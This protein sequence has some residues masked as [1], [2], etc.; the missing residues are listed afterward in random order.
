MTPDQFLLLVDPLPEPT[1]LVSSDG[2]IVA[3]NHAVEERLGMD[4]SWLRTQRLAEVVAESADEVAHFLRLC[5][6]SRSLVIGGMSLLKNGGEAVACRFEGAVVQPKIKGAAALLI[7]RIFPIEEKATQFNALN[8]RIDELGWEVQRRQFAEEKT[9]QRE[10]WLKVTLQSIGDGVICTDPQ[11]YVT[12]MNPI[13][14]FL[15][16]WTEEESQAQP[17]STVFPI[18]NEHTKKPVENPVDKVL[19]EGRIVG[20]ANHTVL[21]ARDGTHRPIDDSAAPIRDGSGTLLG[22]VLIFRDVSEQRL[23]EQELRASEARKSAIVD[24]SLDCIIT[25]DHQ[26]NVVEFNPAAERTFGHRREEVIGRQLADII[27]PV[28]LRDRHKRGMAHY[29]TT[30]EG[31]VLGKRLELPALR[32]DGTEFP[33]ELA[34]TR[35]PTNGP[36]LFTA[37]LRDLSEL[38]RIE[39]HRN[40]RIAVTQALSVA[41]GPLDG[42][43]GLLQAVCENLG[44]EVG[45]YWTV[46]EHRTSLHCA[47]GWHRSDLIVSEFEA[48]SYSRTFE[49]GEGLPGRVWSTGKPH[50]LRDVAKDPK[51]P[52]AAAADKYDLHSAVAC[53]VSVDDRTL[54]VIEFFTK[55]IHE[56][57]ADELEMLGTVAGVFG[58]FLERKA[59]DDQVRR[60]ERELSDFFENATVGLH[61]VGS[62]GIILRVNRAELAL[63][64]YNLNEYVGH[65]ITDFHAD[66]N[67]ICDI[68][69]R[70]Q[71]GEEL[72]EYPARLRCKDGSIKDVLI[73]SSVMFRD[74]DFVHTRCFT[75]DITERKRAE[76]LLREQEQRTRTILESITDAF[77]TLDREWRFTYVNRQAEALLGRRREDLMGRDHW[78]VFSDLLGTEV[79]RNY[80]RAV[81]EAVAV[82]FEFFYPPQDRWYE[83]HA[84]PSSD[85]LS[86][87]FRD[88]SQRRRD[89]VALRGSE[90]KL[91]LLADTI[92]QLAWMAREDGHIFWYNR[93]WY[94]Y[95]GTTPEEMEGWGWQSVHDPEVLPQVLERWKGSIASGEPFDMVFPIKGADGDFRPF[96]TRVNP[97]VGEGGQILYW[98]GTNTDIAE[99]RQARTALAESEERLR[100]A[101]VAGRMGV[102]DWN[103]RTGGLKWSDSLEPLHGLAPGTF[104]GTFDHFQQLIHPDDRGAVNGAIRQSLEAGGEFYVE[105][106]NVLQNGSIHWIA[107]SGKVFRGDDGQPMRMIGI[108]LDVTQRKRAEQTA[109]FLADA[110][111]ALAVLV[112]FDST[113]QKISSLAVPSFADWATVDMVEADGSLRR[114]SVSHIDPAKVQLAHEVHRRSPP[115]PAAPQGVWTI[116]RTGRSEIIP[117]ITDELLVQSVHDDELLGILRQLGLKSYIGVPL[118][119][120]GKTLGVITFINAESGHRYDHID[121][122]VA[123]DLANRAAIAIENAQLYRELRDADR[124]KDEFLATLAHELRNPLAPIRNGLQ[125]IRLTGSENIV[126]DETRAMMERQLNQMIRLVDDLLDVSRITRDKLHLKKQPIE[127]AAVVRS[128]VETSLPLIEQ[129]GHTISVSLPPTPIYVDADL[130][131]L[132]Q[133]FL[134]LLNNSAKYTQPGGRIWLVAE[135]FESEVSVKVRDNGLG[136][137]AE[138]LPRI[139]QMFSQVDRNMEMA[140]GGLGIGLTLVRRLVEMHGGTVDA[141]SDG[142]GHG[143]EFTVRLPILKK[144]QVVAPLPT[145]TDGLPA[146]RRILIVED[147]QDS[148]MSLSTM[149]KLMGNETHT[150]HDGLAA[151]EAAEQFRP[152]MILLDIGL[153]KMNGYDTCRYI[154]GQAWSGGMEIVAL[155]G[156]GQEEDRRRSKEAGFDHHMVKPV[157]IPAIEKLLE[158]S[159]VRSTSLQHSNPARLSLRVLVV[160]DMRDATHMLRTLLNRYGHDVRTAADGPNALK[161]ALEFQPEV[162]LLDISLPGM[163]GLEIARWIR[164]QA[165][166]KEIVLIAMTGYGDDADRQ[167]SFEAG[168]NHHLVKPADFR[169][170]QEILATVKGISG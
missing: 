23:A 60:S 30:G 35:I 133:V 99:L 94:E 7:L 77:C 106:R 45:F 32:A 139:F 85:G 153:P 156:W 151:V 162:A 166:L 54:G 61:W 170:V 67:V 69:T 157:E 2:F 13:A 148:A 51:F 136:I 150:A 88:V 160:D 86:I 10:E 15:T 70:L 14:E 29:L 28:S 40:A 123:E 8:R 96:L 89:E 65:P 104:G 121:L 149:L 53:P 115:D 124:R 120:R 108:G 142:P 169:K 147:N 43:A 33:V 82:T 100:L 41:G 161:I 112:D 159:A 119:V 116:L 109:R 12:M 144:A 18:F 105:F 42:A 165:T 4:L 81:S 16:G 97:L 64:G 72:H 62:D 47:Q 163:S 39:R 90:E 38:K 66:E 27:I 137:P 21:R 56:P 79:E 98:F 22:V 50:W 140:Q 113:L 6:R 117:E 83:L 152:D 158:A 155:T 52:R 168:F 55:L 91:R 76:A 126:I 73:D 130:T 87:Y 36:A 118:T 132:A 74:G 110:S 167:R 17:L 135:S 80:R 9:R 125:V 143:S 145:I 59:A 57:D 84:Y 5:S 95:T 129:A 131:R 19:R 102:W 164:Q 154:R 103:V 25:M 20:L 44:W 26:G 75:R 49:K 31:P 107:G 114:V 58:Q 3:G 1:L 68:L 48:A 138:A 34:I 78:K 141:H 11:G 128:A 24:T 71:A 101:L 92:P 93:R 63:L 37:Y 134:N 122:A 111:A 127:L 146:K 46:D